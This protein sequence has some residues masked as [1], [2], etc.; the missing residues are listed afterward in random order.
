M[1]KEPNPAS[2]HPVY[3]LDKFEKMTDEEWRSNALRRLGQ[4]EERVSEVGSRLV[5]LES[6]SKV[7]EVRGSNVE[8]RLSSI[9]DTL[10]FLVRV[11]IG[12]ILA[13]A[14]TFALSGGF[15]V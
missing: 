12:G 10:K 9:E 15:N 8:K 14:L 7:D 2:Y 13:A 11:V 4:V 1:P 3:L 6:Q 5:A